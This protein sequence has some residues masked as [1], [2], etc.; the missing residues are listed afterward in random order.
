MAS[1]RAIAK[2]LQG[3]SKGRAI[4]DMDIYAAAKS[5]QGGDGGRH[6]SDEDIE[7]VR[8]ILSTI[9]GDTGGRTVSDADVAAM[10]KRGGGKIRRMSYGRGGKVS[11]KT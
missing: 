4:D 11:A 2:R 5:L 8:A 9:Q 1:A 10:S 7:A 3:T 6:I